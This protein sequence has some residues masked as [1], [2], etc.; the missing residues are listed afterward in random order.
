[1]VQNIFESSGFPRERVF[2]MAGVLD[3]ARFRTF[4]SQELNVSVEDVQAYVLGGHG[5]DMVPLVRFTT[6]GRHPHQRADG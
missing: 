5:D 1:M 2:G 6:V 4:I 3:T